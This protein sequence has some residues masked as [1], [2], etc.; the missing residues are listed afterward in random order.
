MDKRLVQWV[1]DSCLVVGWMDDWMSDGLIVE[2][3]DGWLHG[4]WMYI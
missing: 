3:L 4:G 2:S 1:V